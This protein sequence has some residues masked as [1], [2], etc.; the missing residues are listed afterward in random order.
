M[1]KKPVTLKRGNPRV[2]VEDVASR[3]GLSRATVSRALNRKDSVRPATVEKVKKAI[4]ELGYVP[5]AS[6]RALPGGRKNMIAIL[7][8]DVTMPYYANLLESADEVAEERNYHLLIQTREYR[9]SVL[10]LIEEQRADGYI[11]RNSGDPE[12]DRTI[13]N[14]LTA[15]SLPF[16]FIGKPTEDGVLHIGVDNVG[17]A[18]EMAHHF[19]DHGFR[20]ILFIT[21]PPKKIDSNDRIYGFKL[22]LSERG[23]D[24]DSLK[25]VEGNFTRAGGFQ[26]AADFFA[27]NRVEAVFAANDQMALGALHYFY[28]QRIRVP[29]DVALAGFDDD[30]FAEFLCPPL[31]TVRQPMAEIGAVAV[32]NI[33]LMLEGSGI[34]K[35]RILLPTELMIRR[36][37]GC[38]EKKNTKGGVL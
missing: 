33:I 26:A 1:Y 2:T 28:E 7:L 20:D 5:D 13:V 18:R 15:N 24:P 29:Q 19:A 35:N 25:Y 27:R 30:F 9:S 37:C 14:K 3:C 21:G 4:A 8:P 17:G 11:I 22:G 32:E 23:V 38:G 6:A 10:R 34:R 31:S 16:I 36:S 12:V